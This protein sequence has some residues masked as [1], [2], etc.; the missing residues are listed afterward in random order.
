MQKDY[1]LKKLKNLKPKLSVGKIRFWGEFYRRNGYV[2]IFQDYASN[3]AIE[4]YCESFV[5]K[6]T[7]KRLTDQK[8]SVK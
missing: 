6:K 5:L 4:A 7:N 2:P 1:F 8:F 3:V